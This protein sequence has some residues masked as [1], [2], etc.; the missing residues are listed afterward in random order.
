M[1]DLALPITA[2]TRAE[3]GR[4]GVLLGGQSSER[5]ISLQTGNAVAQALDVAGVEVVPIDLGH[6]AIDQIR[7]EKLDRAFIALHGPGGGRR[8]YPGAAGIYGYSLC[9]Q[10]CSSIVFGDG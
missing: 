9:G 4:V 5:E 2:K 10:W 6:D 7:R 3:L 8:S 1:G